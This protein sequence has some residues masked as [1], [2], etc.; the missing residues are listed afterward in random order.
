VWITLFVFVLSAYWIVTGLHLLLW[1]AF[2]LVRDS[3]SGE[4]LPRLDDHHRDFDPDD[5]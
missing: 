1:G 4:E 5:Y 3:L 2:T